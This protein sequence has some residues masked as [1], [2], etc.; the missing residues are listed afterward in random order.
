MLGILVLGFIF[1]W[2]NGS[3]TQRHLIKN[4]NKINDLS[5]LNI[6][7]TSYKRGFFFA[8]ACLIV[9]QNKLEL[10]KINQKILHFPLISANKL[11]LLK[12]YSDVVA[13]F[14]KD[15]AQEFHLENPIT[16]TTK[17]F[18]DGLR[19]T[20]LH[21][22][23]INQEDETLE[24]HV[25]PIEL[26]LVHDDIF[27]SYNGSLITNS[28]QMLDEQFNFN[29]E[30]LILAFSKDSTA[31]NIIKNTNIELKS[32][33]FNANSAPMAIY[34]IRANIDLL[35]DLFNRSVIKVKSSIAN[36]KI[37][38]QKFG[39]NLFNIEAKNLELNKI[40][41]AQVLG[42]ILLNNYAFSELQPE[43]E[44]KL[45]IPK[46][47]SEH[48][49]ALAKYQIYKQSPFGSIDKRDNTGLYQG[50]LNTT[51]ASFLQLVESNK[52]LVENDTLNLEINQNI[53]ANLAE[54]DSHSS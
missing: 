9:S 33:E 44:L 29:L 52:I 37:I 19:Q 30:G 53:A 18:A 32:L 54:D 34:N 21:I 39:L 13:M 17:V 40:D 49:L 36:A 28:F 51:Q 16:A 6:T 42:S 12:I 47:F 27:A 3:L 50:F 43:A 14:G 15:V 26:T 24:F 35:Q 4:V 23:E 2:V 20:T 1:L 46:T 25:A 11:Q 7:I 45:D 31:T 22:N 8:K 38:E 5:E 41:S 10:F 48:F